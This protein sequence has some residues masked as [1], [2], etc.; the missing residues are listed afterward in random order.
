V[1]GR[2]AHGGLP[3]MANDPHRVQQA[4]SLR[5]WAH[6]VAP[7]WNVIGGG[8]PALPG[9][10]IGHNGTGAWGLTILGIDIE[11]L[12]V[13]DTNPGN[14]LQYRYRGGWEDMRV[15]R[16]TS[17]VGAAAPGERAR[18][19]GARGGPFRPAGS[20]HEEGD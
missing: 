1:S 8:E 5:Y 14:P 15:I 6:L 7:G 20:Q 3:I 11:D 4:P 17:G 10:S 18:A 16:E 19:A 13:Y 12:Y 9:I 2:L